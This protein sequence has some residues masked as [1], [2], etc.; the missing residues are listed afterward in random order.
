MTSFKRELVSESWD[1]AVG[2]ARRHHEEMNIRWP[3][4]PKRQIYEALEAAG[5]LW[6]FTMRDAVGALAGYAAFNLTQHPHFEC[7]MAYQ[8]TIYVSHEYR[9]FSAGKFLAW[10]DKQ[11]WAAGAQKI[12]RIVPRGH[13]WS[14]Q[15]LGAGYE[16]GDRIFTLE[17]LNG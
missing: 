11:M 13:D 8:D 9:G 3:F 17:R 14:G 1:E 2:L 7:L 5:I 10:T 15:L 12:V 16:P 4:R 6:L